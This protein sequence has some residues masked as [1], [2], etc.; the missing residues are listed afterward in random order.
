MN[1]FHVDLGNILTLIGLII[2]IYWYEKK[3]REDTNKKHDENIEHLAHIDTCLDN[4]RNMVSMI[5]NKL[6][7]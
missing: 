7:K 4:L 3:E 2:A 6:I 1:F 5:L